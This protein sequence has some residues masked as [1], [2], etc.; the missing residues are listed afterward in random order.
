[1]TLAD[2]LSKRATTLGLHGLLA[3]LSDVQTQ[4]WVPDLLD[5][6]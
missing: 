3:H 5:W 6:E 1:M 4:S 2:S